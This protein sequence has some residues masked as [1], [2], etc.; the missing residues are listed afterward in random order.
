M[1]IIFVGG[2]FPR[3]DSFE[4]F[5][6]SIHKIQN[7]ANTFQWAFISGLQNNIH[8]SVQLIT[9]PFIGWFPK[10]YKDLFIRT[11][12]FSDEITNNNGVLV[13]FC[14]LPFIKSI[15][16][17]FNLLH[18]INIRLSNYEDNVVIVYTIDLAY[19]MAALNAKKH[20]PALKVC[21]IIPDLHDF[22]G[23]SGFLYN[24]YIKYIEKKI[25]HN[26][27]HRIDAYVLLTDMVVDYLGI[28]HKPWIRIEG[29]YESG[30]EEIAHPIDNNENAAAR[31]ILYTGTLDM[32]YGIAELLAAFSQIG[33]AQFRLW[34]CGGGLAAPFV[35]EKAL[36]DIRI[37]YFGIVSK[38]KVQELQAKATVLINPRNNEGDYNKY[39]FPSK[40]MEYLASGTPT[41]MYR[42]DGVPDEYFDYC[43]TVDDNSV[44]GLANAIMN[45]CNK[46]LD[47]LKRMG[48]QAKNFILTNKTADKQCSKVIMMLY[49]LFNP[50]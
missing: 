8:S 9:A 6:K 35:K 29:L 39:S 40:T 2:F 24:I 18:Q 30:R 33:D 47:E 12:T 20:N 34:V 36:H 1:N 43:Y 26:Q 41:L 3:Q 37:T 5:K 19:L 28:A 23:D 10:Y 50:T 7:S 45:V 32:K 17:Y 13:G 44:I 46:D 48:Q 42:L 25:F 15:F 49:T 21:V 27:L 38:Q 4:I 31:V 22:L 14:N 11:R 16:K